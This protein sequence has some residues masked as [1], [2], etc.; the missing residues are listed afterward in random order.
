MWVVLI[1]D[2]GLGE[3]GSNQ[4]LGGQRSGIGHSLGNWCRVSQRG[5]GSIGQSWSSSVG[6][7]N[8][9]SVG[10]MCNWGGVGWNWSSIGLM[11]DRCGIGMPGNGGIVSVGQSRKLVCTV[12]QW[13]SLI[14]G[15]WFQISSAGV[16]QTGK[17]DGEL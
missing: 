5:W 13:C 4:G 6:V 7:G 16:G 3:W 10:L 2:N 11:S 1:S 14:G 15:R 8:W 12:G 9:S 17:Q